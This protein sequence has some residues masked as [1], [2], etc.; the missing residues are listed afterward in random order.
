MILQ[1]HYILARDLQPITK[2]DLN[3]YKNKKWTIFN[4]FKYHSICCVWNWTMFQIGKNQNTIVPFFL[5]IIYASTLL[6]SLF[7]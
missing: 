5:R 3:K 4:Q 2:A 1:K 6:V 7:V